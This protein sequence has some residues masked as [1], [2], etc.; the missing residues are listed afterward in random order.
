MLDGKALTAAEIGKLADLEPREVLLAK[1]AGAMK[2]SMAGA[3]ATFNALPT[4][5]AL[6]A[7]ALRAKLEAG[8]PAA[9]VEDT[10]GGTGSGRHAC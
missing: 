9:A 3:A 6:L 4:Q 7:D 8:A 10:A 1:L 2:A 5:M